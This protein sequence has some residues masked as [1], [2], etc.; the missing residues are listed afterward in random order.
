MVREAPS[1]SDEQ[2]TAGSITFEELQLAARNHAMPAEAVRYPITPPGLHY[3]LIHFD[4]PFVDAAS[5][6]LSVDGL[7]ERPRALSL[8]D[9]RSRPAVSLPVTLECAG[10]GRALLDP[11][12]VSQPWLTE[13][14]GTAI[15]MGTPLAPILNEAGLRPGAV[16]ILFTG[17]DRGVQG[18]ETQDYQRSL[19][20][21]EA[22]RQDVLLAYA[23]NG[24]PL[25][26]QHGFPLRLTVPGWYGMT[27]VKWLGRITALAEP[28]RGFQQSVAYQIQTTDDGPMTPV[29]RMLPRSLMELPGIPDFQSRARFLLPGPCALRGRAWSGQGR[30][31]RVE[32]S[33]DGGHS[34]QE[35]TL[36][37]APEGSPYAWRPWT[38]MWQAASGSYDLC[39]R[40]TDETGLTQPLD[41]PWNTGGFSNNAVQHVTVEVR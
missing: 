23:M 4:I 8:D 7:V 34:W 22:L 31:V 30:V 17:L 20:R 2:T 39:S 15:W 6:R 9:L 29:T 28:F 37:E 11:R 36:G 1:R 40:A 26:P 21:D 41:A 13:A 3:L 32:V 18:G 33:V 14:V 25:L 5:W 27:H 35:A 38:C 24:E 16:E 10:N 19:T 12:P